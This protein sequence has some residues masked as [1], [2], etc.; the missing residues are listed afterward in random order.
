MQI[1]TALE[2]EARAPT[3]NKREDCDTPAY[4]GRVV[5]DQIDY[6][7]R[8]EWG[9]RGLSALGPASD[10]VVIVDVLSF[11]T[12]VDAAVANGASVLPYLYK[13]D[14]AQDFA[15]TKGALL[16]SNRSGGGY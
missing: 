13:D 12:A 9:L 5:F 14:S 10:V 15:R 11:S 3:G 6:E 1:S 4:T 16:A 8:C 2:D 7:V